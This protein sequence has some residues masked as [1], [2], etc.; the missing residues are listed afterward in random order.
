MRNHAACTSIPNRS[1]KDPD[2]LTGSGSRASAQQLAGW[3]IKPVY[4]LRVKIHVS[5]C[6]QMMV[7]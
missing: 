6:R 4:R 3:V 2:I 5:R 1:S 7:T